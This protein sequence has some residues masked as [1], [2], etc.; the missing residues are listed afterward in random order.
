VGGVRALRRPAARDHHPRC[1][2]PAQGLRRGASAG[3]MRSLR[4]SFVPLAVFVGASISLSPADAEP[5]TS[6]ATCGSNEA[7][8][9]YSIRAQR[10]SCIRARQVAGQWAEQCAQLRTGHV[11]VFGA[12]ERPPAAGAR[13]RVFS[14]LFTD[15]HEFN[16]VRHHL[17]PRSR[18]TSA[19]EQRRHE[20]SASERRQSQAS[21]SSVPRT[22]FASSRHVVCAG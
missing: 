5:T 7:R 12:E 14:A 6:T 15:E 2:E 13:F 11:V 16:V 10:V 19:R 22:C 3:A 4:R 8:F 20:A 17:L 1:Q 9:L 21:L 18:A